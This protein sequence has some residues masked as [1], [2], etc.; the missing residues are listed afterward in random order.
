MNERIYQKS[1]NKQLGRKPH[2]HGE[3]ACVTFNC[4]YC[5]KRQTQRLYGR[6]IHFCIACGNITHC[7]KGEFIGETV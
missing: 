2:T 5:G 4:P 6:E 1:V 3:Y 7:K